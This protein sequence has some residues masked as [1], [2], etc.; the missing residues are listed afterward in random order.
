M[1]S[2]ASH[3]PCEATDNYIDRRSETIEAACDTTSGTERIDETRAESGL[4][5]KKGESA[6]CYK[7]LEFPC[8]GKLGNRIQS[9][10]RDFD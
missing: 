2:C 5:K 10:Q 6:L 1:K 4:Q 8:L 7:V 9:F 3:N